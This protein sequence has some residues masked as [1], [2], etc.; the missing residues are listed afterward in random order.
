M[1]KIKRIVFLAVFVTSFIACDDDDEISPEDTIDGSVQDVD[2]DDIVMDNDDSIDDDDNDVVCEANCID[3]ECG[4][5]SCGSPCG[6]CTGVQ[7][8]CQEYKCVCVPDCLNKQCGDDGCGGSCGECTEYENSYCRDDNRCRCT[9]DCFNKECG[10]NGCGGSCGECTEIFEP[11]CSFD[12]K[13]VS[14]REAGICIEYQ[15]SYAFGKEECE[16]YCEDGKCADCTPNCAGKECG[17]D[18]CRGSCGECGGYDTCNNGQC[19]CTPKCGENSCGDDG[20]GGNCGECD[21]INPSM[22]LC[23]YYDDDGYSDHPKNKWAYFDIWIGWCNQ[24][25]NCQYSAEISDATVCDDFCNPKLGCYSCSTDQW[26]KD[27]G[28]GNRCSAY[29]ENHNGACTCGSDADCK[30]EYIEGIQAE[31]ICVDHLCRQGF[32]W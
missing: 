10:D 21:K 6:E 4:D 2:N 15:C 5:D 22:H 8:E 24:Y 20:C 32:H 16:T 11:E 31:Q 28:I 30:A 1:N 26:C 7:E 12:G 9:P 29:S 18:G 25:Q 19:E 27:Q 13:S 17:D 14:Y 3:K 23:K